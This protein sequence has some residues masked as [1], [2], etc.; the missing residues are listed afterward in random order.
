MSLNQIM[1]T[2]NVFHFQIWILFSYIK[3]DIMN[4]PGKMIQLETIIQTEVTQTQKDK[5]A[6]TQLQVNINH[7]VQDI[8][9]TL[10]RPKKLTK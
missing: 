6:C 10:H 9:N 2:E 1:D 4:F 5:Q 8:H 3:K 7:K